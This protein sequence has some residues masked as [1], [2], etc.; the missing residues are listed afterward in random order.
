MTNEDRKALVDRIAAAIKE[1]IGIQ[2][3]AKPLHPDP[4]VD[5]WAADGAEI[6]LTQVAEAVCAALGEK[7][8]D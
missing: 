1:N 5:D 3:N 7:A 2:L 6:N 4:S 8:G